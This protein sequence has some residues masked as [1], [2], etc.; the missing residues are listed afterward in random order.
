MATQGSLGLNTL[1]LALVTARWF[2]Q[3]LILLRPNHT[4][5]TL[6]SHVQ[7]QT[8]HNPVCFTTGTYKA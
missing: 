8:T 1:L 4:S 3:A 6:V 2:F 5:L 7:P